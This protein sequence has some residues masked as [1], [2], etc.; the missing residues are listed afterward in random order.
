MSL[1]QHPGKRSRRRL[2]HLRPRRS[3]RRTRFSESLEYLFAGAGPT[4]PRS[5]PHAPPR[6]SSRSRQAPAPS[7]A[8]HTRSA[9]PAPTWSRHKA[10]AECQCR[11]ARRSPRSPTMSS[12][13]DRFCARAGCVS[14]AMPRRSRRRRQQSTV[15]QV[16]QA[17]A[18]PVREGLR[19]IRPPITRQPAS[20]FDS[21]PSSLDPGSMG[22]LLAWLGGSPGGQTVAQQLSYLD[23]TGTIRRLSRREHVQQQS[24]TSRPES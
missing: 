13:D 19:G 1:V 15:A 12:S 11:F 23:T 21:G 4:A 7:A 10:A 8:V 18:Q 14:S 16:A 24:T 17:D 5:S 6:R 2:A 22:F 9:R 20:K 3:C